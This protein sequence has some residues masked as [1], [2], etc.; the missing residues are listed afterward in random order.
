[1][2]LDD[3]SHRV[4]WNVVAIAFYAIAAAIF[5]HPVLADGLGTYCIETPES[6]DPQIFIWGLAWYPYAISHRLDPLFTNL[7]FAPGGYN[8]AWSTTIPVPALLMWP[9][10]VR[11]GPLVSFNLLSLFTPI[12]SAFTAFALCRHISRAALSALVGGFVYGFSTYQRIESD[13]LNLALTFVPPLLVLL[14]SWRLEN[15]VGRLR[16]E[17]LLFVCLTIQFLISP[18][19]FTTAILFGAVAIAASWW[20]GDSDFR[21]RL[22]SP[23]RE[24]FVAI[25]FSVVALSPY[26]YRFIPSPFGLSPIYNPAHCS[27]DL[28][29]L[30]FPTGASLAGGLKFTRVLSR[31]ISFG[32]EPTAYMGLLP[33][34]VIWLALRP[35]T[36]SSGEFPLERFLALLLAV[37]VVLALG[38]VIH[39]AGAAIAPSIWL[40][41]LLFPIVNNALPARFVLYGF[42]VLSISIAFWL[43]DRRRRISIRWLVAAAAVVSVL[44][45]AIPAAKATIPFFRDR[46]Y[47]DY[48][49]QGETVM[50]LPFASNGEAMQWQAQSA[51]LFRV[52]GG[53]FSV[54]PHE[55]AA[56]P[57]VPALLEEAPYIP[58]YADQ[59][60]TFL[61]AHDARAIIVP[62]TEYARYAKLC[63]SLGAAPLH[64]GGVVF[65]RL[66]P[67]AL[68]PFASM[69]AA[70]MDTRYNLE[71]FAILIRAARDFLVGGN[72]SRDLSPLATARS[73][74][75]DATVAG[76]PRRAQ[77]VGYPFVSAAR[78]SVA[79]QAIVGCLISHGMIRER[80]AVELGP[81]APGDA[82]STSGIWL[83]PWTADSIA[84]G[85]LAGPPAAATLIARFGPHAD[86]IYYPYPL[87]YSKR[88]SSAH[89]ADDPQMLL[90]T[91]KTTALP[92]L[93]VST[94]PHG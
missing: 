78:I 92:A 51:F 39:I 63:A 20:I 33:V 38:P 37:V 90:M 36:K 23:L 41:A 29:G 48:L 19:I 30:I 34:I 65:L 88:P 54:I 89:Q 44:P 40:P 16:Y 45:T 8:L 75:L 11:F 86:A 56:W 77:A 22:R 2:R 14:F 74:L 59:F 69:T 25:G 52:A 82:T 84:I 71:R 62:E 27:S 7:V 24:S 3:T 50:I 80:L 68:I 13:H 93:D 66:N 67:A 55:Y 53:Y 46:T 70:A 76:Y 4:V 1:V 31:R 12:L 47:R 42:L 9:I 64:V 35:H 57:I 21:V 73:G 17:F 49:V 15:R 10:T 61:A 87:P 5:L 91:F 81:H 43:S 28:L 85:V 32:C 60:K 6:N 26:I 58:G 72:S 18:E 83:G 79:V 94:P